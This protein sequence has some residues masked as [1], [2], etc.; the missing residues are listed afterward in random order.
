MNSLPS[1][2]WILDPRPLAMNKG[3][4]P[5]AL[6]ARTGE[7][8]PPGINW[9]AFSNS[10]LDLSNNSDSLCILNLPGAAERIVNSYL[11]IARLSDTIQL[12]LAELGPPCRRP[13]SWRA[14]LREVAA[15]IKTCH[16]VPTSIFFPKRTASSPSAQQLGGLL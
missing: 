2:S 1:T 9:L 12:G 10:C 13:F 8:T 15:S 5:T 16:L 11:N 3:L 7:F 4:P 14:G 6:K